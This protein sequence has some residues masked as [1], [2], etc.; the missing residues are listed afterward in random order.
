MVQ[1]R[2]V[3]TR[4]SQLYG[5][6]RWRGPGG[7]EQHYKVT[8]WSFPPPK[9][10]EL[11]T[12]PLTSKMCRSSAGRGLTASLASGRRSGFC[13]AP[14]YRL[15]TARRSCRL[16]MFL[17]RRWRTN[18]WRCAGSSILLRRMMVEQQ[19]DVLQFVGALVPV[20]EQVAEQVAE[21]SNILPDDIPMRTAVRDTQLAEQLVEVPT[22]VSFSS[23]QRIME[24]NVDIAV[25]GGGGRLADIQGFL[26]G[27][28]STGVEQIVDIPNGGL[29]GSRPGQGSPAS[30]SFQSPA[31]SD[32]DADEP[33]IGGFRT[34]P[35]SKKSAKVT[36]HSSARVPQHI[37]S[38]SLSTHQ[39]ASGQFGRAWGP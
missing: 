14:W 16:S 25:P 4:T 34:F 32:D 39:L 17:C 3:R 6:S 21:M 37:S 19:V 22:I 8:F 35:R 9:R 36:P 10:Q 2:T 11:S 7:N 29:H 12:S 1:T 27:Q 15:S 33:G 13:G 30:S 28:S 24:Q 38:S 18:W 20:A 31:A 26:C 5:D 23:L